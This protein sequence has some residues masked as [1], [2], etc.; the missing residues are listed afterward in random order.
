MATKKAR[1]PIIRI[2]L[3]QD[4]ILVDNFA[5]GGGASSGVELALGRSPDIAI[6]HDAEAIAMHKANHPECKHYTESVWQVDPVEACAGRKVALAWFS[7]DCFPAGTLVLT[8][9]GYE[10]IESIQVGD[11][12]LTHKGRWREVTETSSTRRP[13]VKLRG[14]GHPG[15]LVS[16]EHP[17]Y[18][19]P[20]KNGA[21]DWIKAGDLDAG[22]YWST[23]VEFPATDVPLIGGRGMEITTDLMWLAGRYVA[24]GWTRL[25]ET[26]AELVISCGRHEVNGL[27]DRLQSWARTG[28]RAGCNELAWSQRDIPSTETSGSYQFAT[29]HRGLVTWLRDNFGHGSE[30]KSFPTWALGM[31]RALRS[32]LL[33]GYVS[34]DGWTRHG[35]RAFVE[36]TTVSKALAFSTKAL[37]ASLGHTVAVYTIANS[38]VIEGRKVNAL[39]AWRLRWRNCV[40]EGHVQ[41]VR[42][43]HL[44]FTPVRER[45]DDVCDSAQ[46]FNIGVDEDESYVVEGIVVHN[47]KHFSKAKGTTP[48]EQKI[49]GLAWS[50]VR[51]ATLVK[52]RVIALENVEEFKDW[53]PLNLKTGLA[54]KEQ[55]GKT[56]RAFVRKLE[57]LGYKV[58][59]R[60]L[61]A[62]DYGA[63]TSRRRF[64]MVARCDGQAI[65][66]PE[67]THG[68]GREAPYRTAAECIDWSVPAPSIFGRK[69]AHAEKTLA[70]IA[71]G[72]RR[73]VVQSDNPFIVT[74]RGTSDAH[75]NAST[76][77]LNEPLRTISAG[78]NHH[79]IVVPYL[80]HRSNGERPVKV[81]ADGTVHAAQAPRIYDINNPLGTIMAQGQKHALVSAMLIKHNGGHND[82]CGASGQSLDAPIDSITSRDSKSLAAVTLG[83][84]DDAEARAKAAAVYSFLVRYN[85]KGEPEE[86]TKPLG[87]LTTKDRYGLVT[88]TVDGQEYVI[89]DIGMRML[90]PRELFRAQGFKDDYDITAE[91]VLGAP[92]TKTA[93]VR[94]CGN[95]VPPPMGAAIVRAQFEARQN[96]DDGDDSQLDLQLDSSDGSVTTYQ[97]TRAA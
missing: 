24:D 75:V 66:W 76:S 48:R 63:P 19:R 41:T 31:D 12:V 81:D 14:H 80:V 49:R 87:T 85:G 30:H 20:S 96:A 11:K 61:R 25:T 36:T 92:L 43:G 72:V 58:E 71:R 54:R 62:C 97:I 34:G 42:D 2:H 22:C 9:R 32:A 82:E 45:E 29:N 93:Q 65:V 8:H 38:D 4:E 69:K 23:P 7:P 39:P 51:W 10:P 37:A 17:F 74:M 60:L 40:A 1:N 13:L 67:P 18:A 59:W 35:D 94:M 27:Q 5:G 33:A 73:Y 53:G 78:G 70:R 57:K 6:N 77:P 56:F 90:T 95:S 84:M 68:P 47:C 79:A 88:V 55:K 52:P 50:A 44:E 3:D 91:A 21:A 89:V 83:H 28:L 86:L 26:R 46:V 16:P 15:L 64:F